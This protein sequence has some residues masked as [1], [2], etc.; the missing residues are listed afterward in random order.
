VDYYVKSI[1]QNRGMPRIYLDGIHAAL[2]GFEPG[3]RYDIKIDEGKSVTLVLNADGSRTVCGRL[4][5]K[6]GER[7]R[8]VV[9]INS[10]YFLK[11]FEGQDAVR[12]I[13]LEGKIM[14][15]PIASE[16]HKKD[17]L[18]RLLEKINSSK[19]LDTASMAHGGGVMS[20]ALHEGMLA[21]GLDTRLLFVSEISADLVDHSRK[22]GGPW[23]K[24]TVG[25]AAPMQEVIQ[26]E[27]LM[28]KLPK[29]DVAYGSL[30]C[31]GASIAGAS[32]LG[33]ERMED[34]EEVGHLVFSALSIINRVQPSVLIMENV[35]AYAKTASAQIMRLQLRDQ[36]YNV[37]E[38][39]LR[40]KD[41]GCLEHRD[42][43]V[44]IAI[45][46]GIEFDLSNIAPPVTLVK[47]LGEI[48]ETIPDNDP[49]WS[50]MAGLKAKQERDIAA[51][52]GFKM[53]IF[54]ADS[55][56]VSTIGKGY[57]KVRSTEPKI[58]NENDPNKLR[59]LT[60][61]EHAAVK[62]VPAELIE[63]LSN[64]LA[65]E[66]L[67]QGIVYDPFVSLGKRVGEILQQYAQGVAARQAASTF[68]NNVHVNS[69]DEPENG[70]KKKSSR[71]K[72]AVG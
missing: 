64:T 29:V 23:T 60:P 1:K 16:L 70:I 4:D 49:R 63:G 20:H 48:L 17:R 14:F 55:T 51:G 35:Q 7:T 34:H 66:L 19:P 2:A 30:P 56:R 42:R 71:L 36:G 10:D 53:Q 46:K 38:M 61:S 54:S 9:D 69:A 57:A 50:E 5:K 27:W 22:L 3:D 59:Q 31:S 58:A 15:L 62:G 8:P 12:M 18:T 41:W 72:R 43:Y 44:F 52:K 65:H 28:S 33:L 13:V 32:K 24:D 26:D 67:G 25:L 37:H 40:G 45:T 6:T 68:E 21:A 11:L 39:V 47:R